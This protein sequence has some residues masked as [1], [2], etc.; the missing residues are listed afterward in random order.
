VGRT[1]RFEYVT[2]DI[3]QRS[4]FPF[5]DYEYVLDVKAMNALINRLTPLEDSLRQS[6][7]WFRNNRNSIVR[8]PLKEFIDRELRKEKP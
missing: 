8:K 2:D 6:Y 4:Y 1:P 7:E 5:Y 3:P